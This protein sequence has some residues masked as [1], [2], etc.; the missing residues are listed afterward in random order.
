MT[1]RYL[2]ILSGLSSEST[3][4]C[5]NI[6]LSWDSR[7]HKSAGK[8]CANE[9]EAESIAERITSCKG[10][11]FV[12]LTLQDVERV[13]TEQPSRLASDRDSWTQFFGEFTCIDQF[14]LERKTWQ[15]D[16]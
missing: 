5:L 2:T 11:I 13:E 6:R 8:A 3:S 10:K 12:L 1:M 7:T 16:F 4:S 15:T 14:R 9:Y